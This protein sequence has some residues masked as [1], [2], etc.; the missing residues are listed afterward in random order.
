MYPFSFTTVTSQQTSSKAWV[1]ND[2]P[3]TRVVTK[4]GVRA[5]TAAP[6]PVETMFVTGDELLDRPWLDEQAEDE[7]SQP[8]PVEKQAPCESPTKPFIAGRTAQPLHRNQDTYS[9]RHSIARMPQ[10]LHHRAPNCELDFDIL[11][12]EDVEVGD[13]PY[14]DPPQPEDESAPRCMSPNVLQSDVQASNAFLD[15]LGDDGYPPNNCC[16]GGLANCV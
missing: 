3:S 14:F 10:A 6:G 11:G 4:R 16:G 8:V 2:G 7:H 12:Q 9:R 1:V 13:S 5:R 15:D